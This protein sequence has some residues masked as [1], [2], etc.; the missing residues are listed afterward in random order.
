[1]DSCADD[2]ATLM[3]ARDLKGA[4]LVGHSTGGGEMTRYLGRHGS[5]RVAQA[6]LIGAVPPLMLK[7]ETNL[8]R[9]PMSAFDEIRAGVVADR[10]Q[11]FQDLTDSVLVVTTSRA[12]RRRREFAI[13]SG[14][15][16]CS[17]PSRAPTTVTRLFQKLISPRI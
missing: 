1:M 14:C 10:S 5:A 7:T 12:R 16:G 2:L 15:R 8:G 9:L 11:F 17:A 3:D 13:R 6:V 4:T